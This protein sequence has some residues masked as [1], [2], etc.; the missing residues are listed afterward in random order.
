MLA[1]PRASEGQ[2]PLVA[3]SAVPSTRVAAPVPGVAANA[4]R[5]A[6]TAVRLHVGTQ[7][8]V[9]RVAV[10]SMADAPLEHDCKAP[11][12]EVAAAPM[13]ACV[14]AVAAEGPAVA[15]R[16]VR[17]ARALCSAARTRTCRAVASRPPSTVVSF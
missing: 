9:R 1:T 14:S 13:R 4:S 12:G 10:A 3:S 5:A 17:S 6:R 7:V 11:F 8:R 15:T 2:V 16:P